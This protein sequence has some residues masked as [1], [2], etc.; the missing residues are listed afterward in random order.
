MLLKKGKSHVSENIA[1][2]HKEWFR[3]ARAIAIAL[4]VA[5]KAKKP[6]KP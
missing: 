5:G 1:K 3:Q 6:G 2:L 4:N